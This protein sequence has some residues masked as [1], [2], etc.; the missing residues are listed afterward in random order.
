MR[1][2][3]GMR[4]RFWLLFLL[5][6]PSLLAASLPEDFEAALKRFR[7]EGAPGWSFVQ[8]TE[9]AGESRLERFDAARPEFD[10]WT[11]LEQ[12]GRAP[13]EAEVREYREKQS[14]RSSP[15]NAPKLTDQLDF[16]TLKEV[17]SDE[18]KKHY[19]CALKPDGDGDTVARFLEVKLTLDRATSVF[20]EV[21]IVSRGPFSP[22]VAVKVA[23]MKTVM[24]YSLPDEER[25]SLLVEVTTRLRGRAFWLKSLD[26]DMTVVRSEFAYAGKKPLPRDN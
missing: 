17:G 13:T 24:R 21:E 6:L 19:T 26:A 8:K 10:R 9:A 14:R 15:F 18:A 5:A 3:G 25:P 22:A 23:E 12:D 7:A 4:L 20:E 2:L 11:L 16:E 1:F